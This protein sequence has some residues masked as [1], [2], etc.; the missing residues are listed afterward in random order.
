MATES[1]VLTQT[2]I[3]TPDVS[4][5]PA[6]NAEAM[7]KIRVVDDETKATAAQY[8]K[9]ANDYIKSVEKLFNDPTEP[10]GVG[11]IEAAYR[12]HRFLTGLRGKFT[13]T[14]TDVME[15]CRKEIAAY[16]D[17]VER[18]RLALQRR[19][20]EEEDRNARANAEEERQRQIEELR[21]AQEEAERKQ[22]EAEDDAL[23]WEQDLAV[24]AAATQVAELQQQ[25]EA[26]AAAPIVVEAPRI[27]V[28]EAPKV[29]GVG[30]RNTPLKYRVVD[31]NALIQA[32]AK[33]P[34]LQE[35]L[36]I[37]DVRVK[38]KLKLVGEKI[39]DSVPGVEAYREKS[40]TFR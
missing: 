10:G 18:E 13:K 15:H 24:S 38:A 17:K 14:A 8:G 39:G 30:S 4:K 6:L 19:L 31:L 12:V 9:S 21:K 22:A 1:Q 33:N 40:V 35:Y 5:L 36:E 7:L 3:K 11:V 32:A 20:Q 34:A 23:P 16:D 26:V 29:D 28:P 25:L 27:I 37:N 2:I